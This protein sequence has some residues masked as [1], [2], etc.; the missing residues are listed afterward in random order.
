[1]PGRFIGQVYATDQGLFC[2]NPSD[3][4]VSATLVH[5]GYY[6]KGFLDFISRYLKLTDTMLLLGAHVGALTVPLSKRLAAMTVLEANPDTYELL[7]L[8]LS[9]NGC[10]NVTALNLAANDQ[11]ASLPFVL[12]TD[13]SGS[14]KRY[15]V[16]KDAQ[17]FQDD[18]QI[19]TVAAVPLDDLLF[20][21]SFDLI[22]MDI[23]GSE[24]FAM[25]GMPRLLSQARIVVSEFIPHHLK[26]VANIT[27][28]QFL[29]GL[30]DFAVMCSPAMNQWV[31]GDD[32]AKLLEH[33]HTHDL[34][35]G[36]LIFFRS[37]AVAQGI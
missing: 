35:D 25:K 14:A 9:L 18:P 11:F 13:N 7:R 20:G 37:A 3:R 4:V 21:Q 29:S 36:N 12:N 1:M 16:K 34:A 31:I 17:Y 5:Y 15:P 28:E 27:L 22:F 19:T 23:E 10:T 6:D 2:L 32:I 8:N 30:S 33:M 26:L 24:Y